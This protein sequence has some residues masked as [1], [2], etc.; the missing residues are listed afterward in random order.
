MSRY[1]LISLGKRLVYHEDFSE[2]LNTLINTHGGARPPFF[3]IYPEFLILLSNGV[4]RD[5][6]MRIHEELGKRYQYVKTISTT[7]TNPIFALIKASKIAAEEDF[8]YEE[9][10]EHEYYVGFFTPRPGYRDVLLGLNHSLKVISNLIQILLNTGSLILKIDVKGILAVLNKDI[11]QSLNTLTNIVQVNIGV[12][13]LAIKAI[14][15]AM[16]IDM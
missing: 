4:S 9:G 3:E 12:D 16:N 1:T 2:V 15:K 11:V 8:Y 6:H 5:I 13:Y 7:H 14:E 10:E